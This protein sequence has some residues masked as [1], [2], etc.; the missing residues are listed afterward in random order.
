MFYFLYKFKKNMH[1]KNLKEEQ[2][3][4]KLTLTASYSLS[5]QDIIVTVFSN[6][7]SYIFCAVLG[8]SPFAIYF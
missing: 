2:L 3:C 7:T 4:Q 5:R 8:F 6:Q 1:V